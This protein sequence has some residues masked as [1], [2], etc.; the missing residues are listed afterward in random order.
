M[1][2]TNAYVQ[3]YGQLPELFGRISGGLG[4]RRFHL[5]N[6]SRTRVTRHRTTEQSFAVLKAV[7]FLLPDGRP[8]SSISRIP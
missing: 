1:A 4:A 7:G 8:T 3:V 2:L 6:F 5:S